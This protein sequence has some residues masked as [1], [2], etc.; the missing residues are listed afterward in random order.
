MWDK[1]RNSVDFLGTVFLSILETIHN[2][3]ILR[4]FFLLPVAVGL[5][6]LVIWFFTELG[7]LDFSIHGK[8]K[9]SYYSGLRYG[10]GKIYKGTQKAKKYN[11]NQIYK[12]VGESQAVKS[13]K[14]Q[15]E[16]IKI[17][18]RQDYMLKN[19]EIRHIESQLSDVPLKYRRS[20]AQSIYN[21]K[22][23]AWARHVNSQVSSSYDHDI[24]EESESNEYFSHD[25]DY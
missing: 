19:D 21:K 14:L 12:K 16:V 22:V 18:K 10:Y 3:Q 8:N 24:V 4:I 1:V 23:S 11:I 15:S 25:D 2:T 6:L 9:I 20:V 5:I 13:D 17:Q 7:N